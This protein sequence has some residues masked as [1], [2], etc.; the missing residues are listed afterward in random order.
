MSLFEA[1]KPGFRA[2][3][4]RRL[5]EG[6]GDDH[7]MVSRDLTAIDLRINTIVSEQSPLGFHR[8]Q[9]NLPCTKRESP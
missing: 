5:T 9:A 4:R 3:V 1:S 8:P 6:R 7:V 2:I